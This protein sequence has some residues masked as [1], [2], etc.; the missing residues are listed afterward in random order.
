MQKCYVL[1][2]G[3]NGAGKTTLYQANP[4]LKEMPRINLDEMVRAI[5]SWKNPA[6]VRSAGMKAVRAIDQYLNDGISFNQETTLCG[7]TIM[8]YLKRAKE[9]GYDIELH[10]VGLNSAEIAKARIRQRIRDGG[11]GVPDED[12]DRRYTESLKRLKEMPVLC[13]RIYLY[14]NTDKFRKIAR[15]KDGA[16][17]EVVKI[18]PE[19]M[20]EL[21]LF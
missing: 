11:H 15:F 13:D 8:R 5:G 1:F 12:V 21:G 3:V 4:Q 20:K 7:K 18:L 9:E 16:W 6:D 2:A 17:S 14:D 19:W 10:Y